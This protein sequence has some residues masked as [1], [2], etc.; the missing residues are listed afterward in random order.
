MDTSR[1][2][3]SWL[4]MGIAIAVSS[5]CASKDDTA[6]EK[7]DEVGLRLCCELGALCHLTGDSASE[8]AAE[9]HDIGHRNSPE[10]CRKEYDRCTAA[11]VD[12]SQEPMEH[13]C[14]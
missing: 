5:G 10:D 8:E 2:V 12:V 9:C 3:F 7:K 11:C 13:G 1:T 4:A 6:A 14:E